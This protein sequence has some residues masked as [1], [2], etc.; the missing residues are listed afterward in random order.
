MCRAITK[1]LHNWLK[2][3]FCCSKFWI[4]FYVSYAYLTVK[5]V[6]ILLIFFGNFWNALIV[7]LKWTFL[8]LYSKMHL[9]HSKINKYE[10]RCGKLDLELQ[11]LFL[12]MKNK[13]TFFEE[14]IVRK[15]SHAN[16]CFDPGILF[17]RFCWIFRKIT[18]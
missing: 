15:L 14:G 7:H 12:E 17:V 18:F 4:K 10:Q 6:S 8:L 16:Y 13:I 11:E 9:W 1:T 2:W 3:K 5:I